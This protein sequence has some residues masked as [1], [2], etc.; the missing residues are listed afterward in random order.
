MHGVLASQ[1]NRLQLSGPRERGRDTPHAGVPIIR[2]WSSNLSRRVFELTA[3]PPR[4][5]ENADPSRTITGIPG[6]SVRLVPVPTEQSREIPA[7]G[8]RLTPRRCSRRHDLCLPALRLRMVQS[9]IAPRLK[10]MKVPGSG[11]ERK[12]ISPTKFRP[13][14]PINVCAPVDAFSV[15]SCP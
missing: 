2:Q 11:V 5:S 9:P 6:R 12:S 10:S 8:A 1:R 14:L 13:V 15:K 3:Q 7:I 4:G